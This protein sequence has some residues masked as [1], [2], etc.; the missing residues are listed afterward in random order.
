MKLHL[1]FQQVAIKSPLGVVH[2]AALE[3]VSP[4]EHLGGTL[5]QTALLH[6][7]TLLSEGLNLYSC[8]PARG[9]EGRRGDRNRRCPVKI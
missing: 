2:Y 9:V 1:L 7:E 5:Y 3:V 6:L 4:K 8:A